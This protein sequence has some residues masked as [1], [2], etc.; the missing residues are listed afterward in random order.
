M[1]GVQ[2]TAPG[3]LQMVHKPAIDRAGIVRPS[4]RRFIKGMASKGPERQFSGE[5]SD[6][7]VGC[8]LDMGIGIEALPVEVFQRE[9]EVFRFKRP[10]RL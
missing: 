9:P 3:I 2:F 10:S 8:V 5:G 1:A 7:T 6:A 4:R